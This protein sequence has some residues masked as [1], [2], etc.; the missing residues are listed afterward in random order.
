M[1][2]MFWAVSLIAN[3]ES[4]IGQVPYAAPC[5]SRVGWVQPIPWYKGTKN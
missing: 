3:V 4:G 5:D 1:A 2:T